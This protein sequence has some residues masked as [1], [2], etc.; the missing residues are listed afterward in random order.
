MAHVLQF[1]DNGV[2]TIADFQTTS[3]PG[4]YLVSYTPG[5]AVKNVTYR[6]SIYADGSYPAA[7]H[8]D[9]FV[10]TI[11]CTIV[12]S[13]GADAIAKLR[14][15]QRFVTITIETR[16]VASQNRQRTIKYNLQGLTNLVTADVRAGSVS[17]G[18]D[19]LG[20]EW[21]AF[22]INNVVITIERGH[23]FQSISDTLGT[24][25]TTVPHGQLTGFNIRGD[26]YAAPYLTVATNTATLFAVLA[27]ASI[28][29]HG[30]A[31]YTGY[32]AKG[33]A[34]YLDTAL[35]GSTT[36]A[37]GGSIAATCRQTSFATTAADNP[38]A[39][40]TSNAQ[41]F[42]GPMR[43]F[44]R[45]CVT[46]AATTASMY[47]RY[48][49]A[50]P[51]TFAYADMTYISMGAAQT[52]NSTSWKIFDM[53]ILPAPA[54]VYALSDVVSLQLYAS[55][56]AG[57]GELAIDQVYLMP[58]EQILTLTHQA[59]A[60]ITSVYHYS[61]FGGAFAIQSL[62]GIFGAPIVYK[63]E[64]RP[65]PGQ[66]SLYWITAKSDMSNTNTDTSSI[67]GYTYPQYLT[68]SGE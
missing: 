7:S 42:G 52:V 43:I 64:F 14:A 12:G 15:L 58:A 54:Q 4:Y 55:R 56:S 23:W 68:A 26:T 29:R 40:V 67:G 59:S 50:S 21:N 32:G 46:A 27:Y 22:V 2:G 37:V 62:G 1:N 65:L 36:P 34:A 28:E 53:G 47:M 45:A 49:P 35:N 63:G 3:G 60:G 25:N 33:A 8:Y 38:R 51:T 9:N 11:V 66:G 19:L 48:F 57:A 18:S 30:N 13:S 6:N 39:Y 24:T 17:T 16:T 41:K 61:P 20:P 44:V 31:D 5:A 10:D